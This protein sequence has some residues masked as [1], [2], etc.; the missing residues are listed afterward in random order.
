MAWQVIRLGSTAEMMEDH[1]NVKNGYMGILHP[2][3]VGRKLAFLYLGLTLQPA[4]CV[5]TGFSLDMFGHIL[6][7]VMI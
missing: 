7:S 6:P 2:E 1:E 4:V 3:L 5:L